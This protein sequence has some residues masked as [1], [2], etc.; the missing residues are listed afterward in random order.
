MDSTPRAHQYKVL[1]GKI[2]L[3]KKNVG[4]EHHSKDEVQVIKG[5]R[6]KK[7]VVG[8]KMDIEKPLKFNV[9]IE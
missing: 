6:E 1:P 5:T 2:K 4:E 7:Y 3:K 8:G 9:V